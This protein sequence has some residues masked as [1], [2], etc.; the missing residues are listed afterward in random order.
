MTYAEPVYAAHFLWVH[1][2]LDF[3]DLEGLVLVL[4]IFFV[5]YTHYAFT[6]LEFYEFWV[7]EF[8]GDILFKAE[9]SKIS[10]SL[11]QVY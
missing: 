11:Q 8:D 9:C 2:Y 7:K 4:S 5:S 10:Q 1:I 3:I 6:S